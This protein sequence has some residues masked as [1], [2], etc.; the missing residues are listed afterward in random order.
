MLI[1]T[2]FMLDI[3]D[4]TLITLLH[5]PLLSSTNETATNTLPPEIF[6]DKPALQVRHR[7]VSLS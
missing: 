7:I 2:Q 4:Y 3:Q 5:R 1:Y 6:I